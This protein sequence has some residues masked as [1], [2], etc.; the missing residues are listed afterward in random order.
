MRQQ[1]MFAFPPLT[2]MVKRLLIALSVIFV[3][4]VVVGAAVG[5]RSHTWLQIN[6][7]VFLYTPAFLDGFVWQ[8]LTYM[9]LHSV[10]GFG[11]LFSNLIVLYFFGT[12]V[13]RR[14][15]SRRFL[16][17]YLAAGVIG[18]LT[19]IVADLLL[20]LFTGWY[21]VP[22]VGASGAVAGVM[23]ALCWMHRDEDLNLIL[24]RLKGWHLLLVIIAFDI[25]SALMGRGVSIAAHFGGL[26][27]G[28][29]WMSFKK[30]PPDPW[31]TFRLWRA[32]RKMRAISGGRD[33]RTFLH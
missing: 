26:A 1:P 12:G 25:L 30:G 27:T 15:G 31:Q 11:H 19:V 13:E 17:L 21:V 3:V 16:T 6:R 32:R 29:A 8:P 14:L 9:W 28:V 10:Q 20:P 18:G 7:P 24:F 33:E 23:A 22:T 5:F 4:Q 2:P